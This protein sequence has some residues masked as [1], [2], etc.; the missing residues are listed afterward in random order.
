MIDEPLV[1]AEILDKFGT[2]GGKRQAWMEMSLM[3]RQRGVH[4]SA[5]AMD[6]DSGRERHVDQPGPQEVERHLVTHS[7]RPGC[8]AAQH[9]QIV[10][11]GP[12]KECRF[13]LGGAGAVPGGA[14]LVPE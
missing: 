8:D 12:G 11:R 14:A 3:D 2:S 10:R 9:A 4:R 7:G 1:A 5:A 6:D 13:G